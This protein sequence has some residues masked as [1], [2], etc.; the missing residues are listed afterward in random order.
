MQFDHWVTSHQQQVWV[1]NGPGGL[2]RS[3][4][5]LETLRG[6]QPDFD[7][8]D[9]LITVRLMTKGHGV[10]F[11]PEIQVKTYVPRTLPAYFRQRRRWERGTTKVLWWERRFYAGL[12]SSARL[13]AIETLI[14]LSLY[15]GVFA[16][17]LSTILSAGSGPGVLKWVAITYSAW[18]TINL[19]KGYCNTRMRSEGLWNS[20][21][22]FCVLNGVLWIGVTTWARCAGF[23][24][25]L[26]F[27]LTPESCYGSGH[28]VHAWSSQC[29]GESAEAARASA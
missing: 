5:L 27:L 9:L 14:H 6:M 22:L 19:A 4:L 17:I 11:Y 12:F 3:D 24:D 16:A 25:A 7:T 2:F 1:I 20:Y 28:P 23:V 18:L 13:L 21:V 29:R 26:L 15:L 8:G 10:A